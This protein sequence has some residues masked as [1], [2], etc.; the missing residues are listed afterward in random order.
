MTEIA[1]RQ[2]DRESEKWRDGKIERDGRVEGW[3]DGETERKREREREID[4]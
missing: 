4:K 2:K 3:K 1:G